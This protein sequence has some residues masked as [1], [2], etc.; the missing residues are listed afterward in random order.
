[1][2][3]SQEDEFFVDGV[4]LPDEYKTDSE[5]DEEVPTEVPEDMPDSWGR[6]EEMLKEVRFG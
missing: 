3:K 6:V 1:M 5:E 2:L 4:T